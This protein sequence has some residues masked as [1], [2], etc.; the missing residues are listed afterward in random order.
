MLFTTHPYVFFFSFF[1]G[2]LYIIITYIGLN[3][4]AATFL[5][6]RD[7][8][9]PYKEKYYKFTTIKTNV[10]NYDLNI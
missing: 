2:L 4:T 8:K 5:N 7:N 1:I 9:V 3:K 6:T 10:I